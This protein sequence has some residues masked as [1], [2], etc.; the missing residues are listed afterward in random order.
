MAVR[1]QAHCISAAGVDDAAYDHWS[2]W[3]DR[4]MAHPAFDMGEF[5]RLC[6]VYRLA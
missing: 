3:M 6:Q 5:N 4:W 1:A 2:A